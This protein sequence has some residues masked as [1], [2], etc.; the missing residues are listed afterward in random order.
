MSD[1]AD[2]VE[3]DR[4]IFAIL[5]PLFH[6]VAYIFFN[7]FFALCDKNSWLSRYKLPRKGLLA[8]SSRLILQTLF[9]ASLVQLI[10]G[11]LLAYF[12]FPYFRFFGMPALASPLPPFS[13]VFWHI[14]LMHIFNDVTFYF[15]HRLLHWGVLYKYF[16]KQHHEYKTTISIAAE[17]ASPVEY[18]FS[19]ALPTVGGGLLLGSHAYASIIWVFLRLWQTFETHSGY[20]FA[21]SLLDWAG[22]AHSRGAAHHDFHHSSNVGNF[23]EGEYMDYLFGTLSAYVKVGMMDGYR[24]IAN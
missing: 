14:S 5:V 1:S 9:E 18:L 21:G 2:P 15:S 7:A 17:F 6:T 19:D 22:L 12:L 3:V 10:G 24:K 16:H 20:C 8:P 11:P 13:T 23:G 4:C